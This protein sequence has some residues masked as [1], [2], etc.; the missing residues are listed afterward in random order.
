MIAEQHTT[1][2][3]SPNVDPVS[4][5]DDASPWLE[6]ELRRGTLVLAVLAAL[7]RPK[8]IYEMHKA[9]DKGPLQVRQSTLYLMV[10]RLTR[11]GL[12][13]SVPGKGNKKLHRLTADGAAA[14]AEGTATWRELNAAIA[15]VLAE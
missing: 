1:M 11:Q 6:R 12:V 2:T 15:P 8:G 4:A 3:A 14:L 13:T 5:D 10:G 9:M 7:R